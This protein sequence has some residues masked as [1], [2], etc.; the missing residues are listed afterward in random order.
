[1]NN[2]NLDWNWNG[3]AQGTAIG[4]SS[5]VLGYGLGI[6][7]SQLG[8]TIGITS[9]VGMS[10]F[11][12]GTSYLSSG[13]INNNWTNMSAIQSAVVAGLTTYSNYKS[14]AEI[15]ADI[16]NREALENAMERDLDHKSQEKIN[17]V[18]YRVN[19]VDVLNHEAAYYADDGTG[20]NLDLG[21]RSSNY[22]K[23]NWVQTISTDFPKDGKISPYLDHDT[24]TR[25]YGT[26]DFAGYDVGFH[27]ATYRPKGGNYYWN[28]ELSLAGYD[29]E[30]WVRVMT[31]N[32]GY[33]VNNGQITVLPVTVDEIPSYYHR[34]EFWYTILRNGKL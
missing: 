17:G 34:F 31:L 28:A 1:V 4:I 15:R 2:P 29:G 20:V 25:F 21:Y 10:L 14:P 16:R 26:D 8:S 32:W 5:T 6:L 19:G 27:D 11:A 18:Q 24:G 33:T 3:F 9:R 7:G 12:A 22:I 13:I 23:F 30:K